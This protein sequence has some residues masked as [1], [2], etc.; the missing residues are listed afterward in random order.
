M[1]TSVIP[2]VWAKRLLRVVLKA[3]DF[4]S[5]SGDLLEEYRESIHPVRGP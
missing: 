1:S 2:P 4:E 3:S 5:V